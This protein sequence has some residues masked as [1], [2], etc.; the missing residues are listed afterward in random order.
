MRILAIDQAT[1]VTGYA[2]FNNGKLETY[3]L[4]DFTDCGDTI[5]RIYL[6]KKLMQTLIKE[7][8][9][10]HVVIEDTQ[11][12]KNVL[13]FKILSK[14]LGIFE[15]ALFEMEMPYS[16]CLAATWKKQC[17]IKGRDRTTQK[18]NAQK[19]VLEKYNVKARQDICD[20]ICLGHW[21]VKTITDYA[22]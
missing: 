8:K 14:L 2:V 20:A 9:I 3:G 16:I 12:Q 7:Y 11:Q 15:M 17:G 22:W 18:Q 4:K 10:D 6:M 1:K 19:F 21:G 13:T 5:E